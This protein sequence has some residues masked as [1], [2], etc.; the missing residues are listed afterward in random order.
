MTDT[1]L[2]TLGRLPKGLDIARSFHRAGFR[3]IVAEPFSWHLMRVSRSV[4][5][6]HEVTAPNIDRERYLD[7][8]EWIINEEQVGLVIPVSEETMHVAEL[9]ERLPF[10]VR[11]YT[12][13]KADLLAL[14]DKFRF[15]QRAQQWGFDAPQ[16]YRLSDPAAKTFAAS[17]DYVI[18]PIF[19]C[20][21]HGVSRQKAGSPLPVDD[22]NEPRIV[23]AL[24]EGPV[25]S[26]FS[27]A[28][29]GQCLE[30][31]LYRGTIMTGTVSVGFERLDA[32][33][34]IQD[35]ITA[36]VR[37]S[38]YSG[39]ISFD[40]IIDADERPFAIE[41]NP[42]VTSGIHFIANAD[43]ASMIIDPGQERTP[44]HRAD[45]Q[46]QQFWPSLTETQ[47]AIFEPERFKRYV[48]AL[49]KAKDV[50]WS[51]R[52]PLPFLLMPFTSMRMLW[53]AMITKRSLGEAATYDIEW[54]PDAEGAE[55]ALPLPED[56]GGRRRQ[57]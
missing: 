33:P 8:L 15:I 10:S 43:L 29:E 18:K 53:M 22:Q 21:G 46:L 16:T 20:A 51:L 50:S 4:A 32:Q 7:D 31:V 17:T 25:V 3:V 35:W 1:V 49:L 57:C 2:L 38:D 55:A 36:F 48:S 30:T 47:A 28:H 27:I 9:K 42:R 41:C 39:F 37:R 40:F 54:Q 14:H 44:Q 34:A 12:M 5:Q 19:S 52:D 56:A 6:C 23:Q 45:R 13:H 26:S 24:I 11:V